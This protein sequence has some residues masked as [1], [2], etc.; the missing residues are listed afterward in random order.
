MTE[1]LGKTMEL[2][3]KFQIEHGENPTTLYVGPEDEEEFE[4]LRIL[5]CPEPHKRKTCAFGL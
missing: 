4:R 2:T 1:F 5:N 3:A